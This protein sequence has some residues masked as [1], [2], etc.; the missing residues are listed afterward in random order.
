M[1]FLVSGALLILAGCNDY[2]PPRWLDVCVSGFSIFKPETGH[3]GVVRFK[4]TDVCTKTDRR[5]VVGKLYAGSWE[6]PV[7]TST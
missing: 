7:E 3:D 4:R 5:C 1:R 2:A 6:C